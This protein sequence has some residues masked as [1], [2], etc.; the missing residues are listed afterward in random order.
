MMSYYYICGK[1]ILIK[2]KKNNKFTN[3]L[4]HISN[5]ENGDIDNLNKIDLILSNDGKDILASDDLDERDNLLDNNIINDSSDRIIRKR[6]KNSML[7]KSGKLK[8]EVKNDIKNDF[9]DLKITKLDNFKLYNSEYDRPRKQIE[10]FEKIRNKYIYVSNK[11][12]LDEIDE[13]LAEIPNY[14]ISK[15]I[16]LSIYSVNSF[17]SL[18][19]NDNK[20]N[21]ENEIMKKF[22]IISSILFSIFII[23][24]IILIFLL[25]IL[26]QR[27]DKF[28]LKVWLIPG[29]LI[30]I[31]VNF[32]IYYIIIFI[33]SV[34]IFRSY[35]KRDNGCFI[36]LLFWVFV[37]KT[38]IHIFKLRN[39]IT[40]YKKEFDYL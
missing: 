9:N 36:R 24:M 22:I 23:L 38:M 14:Y 19:E 5:G 15:E 31:F 13:G 16:N 39:L 37:D 12:V 11:R 18:T 32:I 17:S 3:Y 7:F 40:K 6:S 4:K 25:H 2:N 35:Y 27:F 10:H 30:I 1:S 20:E 34:L 21:G 29:I 28:I 26:L 33:G 8:N